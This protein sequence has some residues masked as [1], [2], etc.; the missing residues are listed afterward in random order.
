MISAGKGFVWY[1]PEDEQPDGAVDFST[2]NW[3]AIPAKEIPTEKVH[4][5]PEYDNPSYWE[6]VRDDAEVIARAGFWA[7][8][9][10]AGVSVAPL[11]R[12]PRVSLTPA[13]EDFALL[14]VFFGIVL[15]VLAIFI[16]AIATAGE[17]LSEKGVDDWLRGHYSSMK[18]HIIRRIPVS[19]SIEW[20]DAE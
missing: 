6:K 16:G 7:L 14:A 2:I 12:I 20:K 10:G 18:D 15:G 1:I 17:S 5:H 11:E 13:Q 4:Q 8:V 9:L 19:V 3:D